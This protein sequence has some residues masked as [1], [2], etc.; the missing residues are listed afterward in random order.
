MGDMPYQSGY[1]ISGVDTND[2]QIPLPVPS[3]DRTGAT[4]YFNLL[5]YF[6][7]PKRFQL[8]TGT[9]YIGGAPG[10]SLPLLSGLNCQG[11]SKGASI[12]KAGTVA[13]TALFSRVVPAAGVIQDVHMSDMTLDGNSGPG[14][15]ILLMSL[16]TSANINVIYYDLLFER[17]R[18]QNAFLG[19]AH[20]ANNAN[21]GAAL[22][23]TKH[24]DCTFIN[25][26][27]GYLVAGTYGSQIESGFWQGCT[28]TAIGTA[29]AITTPALAGA[30]GPTTNMRVRGVHIEGLGSLAGGPNTEWGIQIVGSQTLIGDG[31]QINNISQ[32]PVFMQ[33]NE[34]EGSMIDGLSI[35][36]CG[37]E[38]LWIDGNAIGDSGVVANVVMAFVHRNAGA[39]TGGA[40]QVAGGNWGVSNIDVAD[41][42]IN[43]PPYALSLN[44]NNKVGDVR[45]NGFRCPL[46]G[47][48]FV[49]FRNPV[50]DLEI[51]NSKGYNPVGVVAPAVPASTVAVAAQPYD[52][53]FYISTAAGVTTM[54]IQ[55]GPVIPLQASVAGQYVSVPAGKTVTPTYANAPTWVVEGR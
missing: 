54:T 12:I 27:C 29:S 21:A 35:W 52:R 42:L 39:T 22:I 16:D 3:G 40:I 17:I 32:R 25:L 23:E 33:E 15:T 31:C 14:G 4:D 13:P 11:S 49:E 41:A 30:A 51:R 45:V 19:W 44:Y 6:Q 1:Q 53:D 7:N 55:N 37:Y 48:A 28:N 26:N 9:Y 10:N 34:S 5:P 47:T 18:F 24:R 8:R 2:A 36:G 38:A 43:P 46:V 20:R 50:A